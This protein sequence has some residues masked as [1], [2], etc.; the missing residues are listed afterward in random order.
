MLIGKTLGIREWKFPM[1]SVF[2][3]KDQKEILND[4]TVLKE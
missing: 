1:G 3:V 4:Q 2:L